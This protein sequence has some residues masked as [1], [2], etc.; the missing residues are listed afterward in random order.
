MQVLMTNTS[1][2]L[3]SDLDDGKTWYGG[4]A[5]YQRPTKLETGRRRIISNF[6][7]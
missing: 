4:Y 2:T 7:T 5:P 6:L 1:F 3:Q